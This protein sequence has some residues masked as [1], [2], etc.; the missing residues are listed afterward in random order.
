MLDKT[1]VP[2]SAPFWHRMTQKG[3]SVLARHKIEV[4]LPSKLS[5]LFAPKAS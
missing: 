3:G 5:V 4:E 2:R 1:P